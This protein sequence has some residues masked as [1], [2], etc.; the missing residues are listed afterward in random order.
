MEEKEL[1]KKMSNLF[2]ESKKR[3]IVDF[4]RGLLH[5]VFE[6]ITG[7]AEEKFDRWSDRLIRVATR[8]ENL[9][10]NKDDKPEV[11]GE[12]YMFFDKIKLPFIAPKVKDDSVTIKY[13]RTI[14][15]Y[16]GDGG[17]ESMSC[18]SELFNDTVEKIRQEQFIPLIAKVKT[19]FA[20][21]MAELEDSEF[22]W[23]HIGLIE[24]IKFSED[25][26]NGK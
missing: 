5:D 16:R 12:I 11:L 15:I 7:N 2:E 19:L 14:E 24:E 21:A 17:R 8:L 26:N 25:K 22:M 6:P 1:F 13:G 23:H 4:D 10:K 9:Y 20:R 18:P 3:K